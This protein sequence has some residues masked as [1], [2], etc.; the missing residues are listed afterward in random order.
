MAEGME[1]ISGM[2]TRYA[3]FEKLYLRTS[4]VS[5]L[6]AE[7]EGHLNEA[8]C[9][10][11]AGVLQYLSKAKR[12]YTRTTA[13]IFFNINNRYQM[14]TQ[15]HRTSSTLGNRQTIKFGSIY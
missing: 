3:I 15:C 9:K 10:L 11:Y 5:S 12:Y 7:A 4:A 2:I 14:L 8:L 1:F 6:K 13:G